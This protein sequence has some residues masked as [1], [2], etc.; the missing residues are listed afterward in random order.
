MGAIAYRLRI[1]L[2][3]QPAALAL[4]AVVALAAASVLTLTAGALRTLSASDRF[5]RQ[6][7][8]F[9]VTLQQADGPPR[10]KEIAALPAV[11]SLEPATFI[12]GGV[13]SDHG[14]EPTNT[15]VFAGSPT[16]ERLIAGR[17]PDPDRPG[18]FVATKSFVDQ[19]GAQIG[20][21]FQLDTISS[22]VAAASGFDVAEPDGPS[23]EATLVGI[24]DGPGELQDGYKVLTFPATLLDVGDIGV[25]TTIT[26]VELQP[27]ATSDDLRAQLA[28]L[29]G[30]TQFGVSKAE[31]V[32]AP[33]RDA[34]NAQGQGLA[35]LALIVG[36]AAIV[37]VGQLLSRQ[38]RLADETRRALG[39]IGLT[40]RQLVA[41]Q[42]AM[43]AVPVLV[44]VAVAAAI[45]IAASGIFPVSFA[46]HVEPQV[47]LRFDPVGHLAA[48]AILALLLIAWVWGSLVLGSRPARPRR[49]TGGVE[50]LSAR[51]RPPPAV[52]G[53][54]FAF[55]SQRRGVTPA[56]LV[57]LAL[58]LTTLVGAATFGASVGRVVDQ[59]HR[60]AAPD[61]GVGA[62][63]SD[64]AP[65]LIAALQADPDVASLTRYGSVLGT[66][67]GTTVEINGG[68]ALKG[69]PR[70]K[71]LSGHIM[72]DD[73][74][75]VLGRVEARNLGV[76]V[77]DEIR[78]AGPAAA[79]AFTVTGIALIPGFGGSDGVGHGGLVTAE[80]L[81]YL[82]PTATFGSA[83]IDL[84]PGAP[85]DTV[86]RLSSLSE[87]DIGPFDRPAEI[88]NL[89]RI[90]AIPWIVAG[91][92]GL[93]I[94]LGLVNL[95]LV[96]GLH[97]RQDVAVLR[98][99][100]ADRRW[101]TSVF[102]WQAS[103]AAAAIAAVGIPLGLVA[104]RAVYRVFIGRIG[105]EDDLSVPIAVLGLCLL[106]LVALA[107]IAAVT[108]ARRA[109]RRPPARF[110]TTE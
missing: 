26:A 109:C 46:R 49:S 74:E 94:V 5:E 80:A 59:P 71:M 57:G 40:R 90:R 20:D 79:R 99:L 103:L 72:R 42:L 58:V 51:L 69:T 92:L 97:R 21:R 7:A 3:R 102:H 36:V 8:R 63:G 31:W 50:A 15:V 25:A 35:V 19:V 37:I 24:G 52:I 43:A 48:P 30:G 96:S 62:G 67:D 23:L 70:V 53:A 81:T 60:Y 75:I 78:V 100:G 93:L 14:P 28:K 44:G 106:A 65:E 16:G 85:T 6:Q 27:G 88:T 68:T 107:N 13:T 56:S 45:S 22:K 73:N 11:R 77:G 55:A 47:G 87:A 104:G 110:L 1:S 54:R 86:Q 18:E 34:V 108:P 2:R 82:D 98:S 29:P 95:M 12:F 9:D 17:L 61:L 38:V 105:V 66:V 84:R 76:D 41:D 83:S 32:P 10:T 91:A 39:S 4:V 33:V 64:I 101:V 89:T